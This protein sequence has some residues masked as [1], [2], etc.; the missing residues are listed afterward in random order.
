MRRRTATLAAA[1]LALVVLTNLPATR[2]APAGAAD[3]LRVLIVGDSI[4]QGSSGDWTW[5]YRLWRHL[6][7]AEVPVD[8]V[9]HRDDLYDNV[10]HQFGAHDYLEPAFD[11]D[12][13]A[14]WG[15]R[16]SDQERPIGELVTG[17]DP[18]V[19]LVLLGDN[20]LSAGTSP[21]AVG[22]LLADLV[23]DARAVDPGIDIVMGKDPRPHTQP[24]A[25]ELND[26]IVARA[27]QLDS[28]GSRV[29]VADPFTYAY[30]DLTDTWDGAHPNARGEL[31]IA[32]A[33]ENA[34]HALDAALPAAEPIPTVP[35]GPRVRPALSATA[36]AGS[37]ELSWSRSPGSEESDVWVRDVTAAGPFQKVG[38]G[39]TGTTY[40]VTGLAPWHVVEAYTVPYKGFWPA[41]PDAWSAV[42]AAEVLG[43]LE[44]ATPPTVTISPE[45][46]AHAAWAAVPHATSYVLQWRRADQ[47]DPPLGTEE[48]SS[49]A[50]EASGLTDPSGYAFRVRARHGDVLGP[51]SDE[52]TSV[53]PALGPVL[54]VRVHRGR[55]ALRT[56]GDPVTGA[57][58]YT[59]LA[60][61]TRSCSQA[62]REGRFGVVAAGLRTPAARFRLRG[63]AIWVRWVAVRGGVPGAVAAS[64]TD[65]VRH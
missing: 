57:T 35:L 19:M 38:D 60:V 52:V 13:A 1:G 64:S 47:P 4:S 10:A 51:W 45:G 40:A 3:P 50:A 31:K 20:D 36:G 46:R 15:M 8:L 7:D 54:E 24:K 55:H 25:M 63:R 27:A 17:Y 65:C 33:F 56:S 58:S 5:R 53:V 11:R 61:R 62:P 41:E 6:T 22:D 18:D 21:H 28:P 39:V 44:R 16:L 9:G 12:H 2:P 42:T 49:A 48:V 34:L 59:L 30:D 29:L 14:R 32:A 37:V 43:G 26:E 23:Y